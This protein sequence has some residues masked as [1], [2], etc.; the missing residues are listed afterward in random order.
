MII[1]FVEGLI[2]LKMEKVICFGLMNQCIFLISYPLATMGDLRHSALYKGLPT[3]SFLKYIETNET[4]SDV[5][6]IRRETFCF[7]LLGCFYGKCEV[8]SFLLGYFNDNSLLF[9]LL[10]QHLF[11]YRLWN[12]F[13]GHNNVS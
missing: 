9:H 8:G 11:L 13:N 1:I 7:R 12:F 3:S 10:T 2:Y 4:T 5:F 6:A